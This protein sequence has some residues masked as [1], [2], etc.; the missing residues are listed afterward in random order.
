MEAFEMLGVQRGQS[1][2]IVKGKMK[3]YKSWHPLQHLCARGQ[4][5]KG[6]SGSVVG[7]LGVQYPTMRLSKC[8]GSEPIKAIYL[9][10][11]TCFYIH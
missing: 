11:C 6:T 10:M 7:R 4:S 2:L 3:A 1:K 8:S 9:Y 5:L